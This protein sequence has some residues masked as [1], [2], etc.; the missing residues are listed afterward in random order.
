VSAAAPTDAPARFRAAVERMDIDAAGELLAADIVFHSPVTFHPFIGRETVTRLLA[1]VADTFEDFRY[2]D[3][4][5]TDGAHALIFRAS[6][7][8]IDLLR[9]DDDGLICDFTV[10]IRP[11]SGLLPFA[12]TMGEKAAAAGVQTTRPD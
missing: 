11:M 9:L 3:E 7:E 2:T 1:I 5:Q 12:Q 8:G 10:M 4:L 6:V